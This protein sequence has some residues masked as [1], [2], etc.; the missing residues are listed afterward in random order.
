M[1]YVEYE[2]VKTRYFESQ[3][4]FAH[5]LM[6]KER[7]FASTLPSGIRYDKDV[8]QSSPTVPL[9][10]YVA[11]LEEIENK[12]SKARE[13]MSDWEI[14]LKVKEKEVRESKEIPDKVYV[15]KYLE[16]MSV[17]KISYSLSYSKRQIIR[18]LK[19]IEKCIK[20]SPNV[21]QMSL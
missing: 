4:R 13:T 21:T 5:L 11:E 8:V 17:S 9:E 18:I 3:R 1:V 14:L 12:L 6:D 10:S 2:Q 16:K 15:M 7:I 20:M 19:K